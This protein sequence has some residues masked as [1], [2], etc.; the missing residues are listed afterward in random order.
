MNI[1]TLWPNYKRDK[2]IER[3]SP[4]TL[5]AYGLQARLLCEYLDGIDIAEITA[6]NLKDYL[7]SQSGLKISS[8][9][10]RVRFIRSFFK[11]AVE[12]GYIEKNI[13]LTIKEPKTK[14]R[15]PKYLTEEEI[16]LL[17]DACKSNLERVI[18]EVLYSTGSR[19]GEIVKLNKKDIDWEENRIK[20]MGKGGYP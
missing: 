20:I 10:H 11:W 7:Y 2:S 1:R 6:D 8:I 19:I 4:H 12:Q 13:S 3:Y 17:R 9:G 16:E 15:T 18:F 14:D 5:K